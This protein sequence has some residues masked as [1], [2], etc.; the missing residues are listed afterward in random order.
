MQIPGQFESLLWGFT[1]LEQ[2]HRHYSDAQAEMERWLGVPLCIDNCGRC[3]RQVIAVWD[4]EARYIISCIAGHNGLVDRVAKIAEGWLLKE[5]PN[6]NSQ[7]HPKGGT[8]GAEDFHRFH[9]EWV[10]LL[11]SPC[12]FLDSDKRC[13]I[14]QMRPLICRA[15]GV[16]RVTAPDCLRPLGKGETPI[17]KA[18]YGGEGGKKLRARFLSF[19]TRLYKKDQTL[20]MSGFIPTMIYR[21]LKPE[22]FNEMVANESVATAK[23][24]MRKAASPNILWQEQLDM[25]WRERNRLPIIVAPK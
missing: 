13:I 21:N 4:I 22:K 11:N 19:I 1:Q 7:F 6:A 24:A 16:T 10:T 25:T 15:Y 17:R 8:L 2:I 9:V 18:Y 3:C 14:Y 23:M 5:I 20:T 12:P